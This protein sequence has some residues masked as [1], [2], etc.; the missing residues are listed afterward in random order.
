MLATYGSALLIVVASLYVGRAFFA[1]LGR[2]ETLWLETPVGL[3]ILLTVCSILTRLHFGA[4]NTGA[5]PERSELALIACGILL[6]ASIAYLRFGFADRESFL[7]AA[8]VIGVVLVATA[9]PLAASGTFGIPGIG[10]NND[11]AAHLIFAE[12]LQNPQGPS[13]LGLRNG[14]PLGPHGL[15]ATVADALG[16][17][18][19]YGFLGLLIALCVIAGLTSLNL[20]GGLAPGRRTVAASLVA[21]PYL[22]ASTFGIGG[23]KE[24]IAGIF[25]MAFALILREIPRTEQRLGLIAALGVLGAAMVAN[26]SYPGLAWLIAAG[27]LWVGAEMFLAW[28]RGTLATIREE[29]RGVAPAIGIAAVLTFVL[30]AA[31]LPRIRAFID[32]GAVDIVTSTDSKLRHAVPVPEAFGVWPS[33][34]WLFGYS[35]LGLDDWQVFA[36]VG[37]VAFVFAAYWWVRREDL[38]LPAAVAGSAVIYLGTL[39]TSGLY[40]EAKALQVPAALIMLFI[41]GALLLPGPDKPRSSRSA[42]IDSGGGAGQKDGPDPAVPLA[43]RKV[44]LRTLIAVPFIVLAAYSSFLALRDSVIAPTERFDE[45]G[46]FEDLTADALV[47]NLTSDRYFDYYLRGAD[48]RSPARNAETKFAGREGKAQRLPVDFD[49]VLPRQLESFDYAVTTSAGYQS[50]APPNWREVERTESYVLWERFDRTPFVGTLAEEARPGRILRC[51]NPKFRRLLERKGFAIVWPRP[52]IGKRLY[53]EVDGSRVEVEAGE[54]TR[55][56]AAEIEPG[57]TARQSIELPPGVWDLSF[58]YSSPAV[59]LRLAADGL[60]AEL[61]PGLEGVVPYRPDQGPYFPVGEV[62]SDGGPVEIAV[63]AAS[64]DG[65]QRPLG[66]DATASL[67]NVVAT[68]LDALAVEEFAGSCGRYL[69]HYYVGMEGALRVPKRIGGGTV[70]LVPSR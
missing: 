33:G 25:L 6:V 64:P 39:A 7:I 54:S 53:W 2:R 44:A 43:G 20:L 16:T 69:D 47:L 66:V 24:M 35:S 60:E 63:T 37:L 62:S 31:E 68:R 19:L 45:L 32:N 10:V 70:D 34:D 5:I 1:V 13:P 55:T 23:F 58:Q 51:S 59:P 28:R 11:M 22:V 27:G 21:V 4:E 48:V 29:V 12:W 67:G 46:A 40:V 26:Y 3:A 14:Y 8:P 41:L 17:E 49:S 30:A 18:S 61:L 36:L 42:G 15:V 52:V 65:L 9:I 57:E 38:A 50:G 56:A